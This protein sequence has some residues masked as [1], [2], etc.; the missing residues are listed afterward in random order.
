MH[1]DLTI[2]CLI[3]REELPAATSQQ[4]LLYLPSNQLSSASL[5]N[6]EGS[7]PLFSCQDNSSQV[8]HL[9]IHQYLG[10]TQE[11]VKNVIKDFNKNQMFKVT[12]K[13]KTK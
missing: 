3:W 5:Q 11:M 6:G 12:I 7:G 4:S 2:T 10:N 1:N 13:S 9:Y 8:C